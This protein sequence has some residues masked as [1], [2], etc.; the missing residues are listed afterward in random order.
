M[1]RGTAEESLQVVQELLESDDD[2]LICYSHLSC[3]LGPNYK[4]KRDMVEAALG[5]FTHERLDWMI[6][7]YEHK[8]SHRSFDV[9]CK[10]VT[11]TVMPTSHRNISRSGLKDHWVFA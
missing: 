2:K 4:F 11:P 1:N 8:V 9:H 10:K 5:V 3:M 6:R 7:T